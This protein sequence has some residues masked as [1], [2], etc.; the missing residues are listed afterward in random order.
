MIST[1]NKD[2][3]GWI[4]AIS[5]STPVTFY[6]ISLL[7]AF[8]V[9]LNSDLQICSQTVILLPAFCFFKGSLEARL[10]STEI[11]SCLKHSISFYLLCLMLIIAWL[12][13]GW[14]MAYR[15]GVLFPINLPNLSSDFIYIVKCALRKTAYRWSASIQLWLTSSTSVW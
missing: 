5:P 3:L 7:F 13:Q 6:M 14:N 2:I 1:G 4:N 9:L 8:V 10:I 15:K 11:S 12:T